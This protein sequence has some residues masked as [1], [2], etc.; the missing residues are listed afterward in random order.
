MIIEAKAGSTPHRQGR[1]REQTSSCRPSRERGEGDDM[2][3]SVIV[4][5]TTMGECGCA[6]HASRA[7]ERAAPLEKSVVVCATVVDGR[8]FA[9][10]IGWP[11]EEVSPEEESCE[12]V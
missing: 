5:T 2:E 12:G 1:G 4:C 10:H 7:I 3:G 6:L 9:L 11:E 8:G